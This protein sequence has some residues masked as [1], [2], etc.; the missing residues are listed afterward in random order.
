MTELDK[1]RDQIADLEHMLTNAAATIARLESRWRAPG[2]AKDGQVAL[3]VRRG[4]LRREV[5]KYV[6][7]DN[8]WMTANDGY[9]SILAWRELPPIPSDDGFQELT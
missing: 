6:E 1:L 8:E 5:A 9:V 4:S 2:A 7:S 3:V